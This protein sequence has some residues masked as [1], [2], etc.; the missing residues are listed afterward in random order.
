[1]R[2]SRP[3][4]CIPHEGRLALHGLQERLD[5][6]VVGDGKTHAAVDSDAEI[7][8]RLARLRQGLGQRQAAL[9]V[10]VEI[11][12][13]EVLLVELEHLPVIVV[14]H[15]PFARRGGRHRRRQGPH[16]QV[17]EAHLAGRI[18]SLQGE[19]AA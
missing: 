16:A 14:H 8:A 9:E 3:S 19:G 5:T 10:R 4:A 18:V 15:R 13:R 1:L 17:L 12:Q 7:D 11:D 2:H 6:R